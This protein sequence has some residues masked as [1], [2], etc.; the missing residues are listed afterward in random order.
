MLSLGRASYSNQ[1]TQNGE[2]GVRHPQRRSGNEHSRPIWNVG[3]IHGCDLDD[4][5]QAERELQEVK[6]ELALNASIEASRH[7]QF[8]GF[9]GTGKKNQILSV[10]ARR[11]RPNTLIPD[12]CR[13]GSC[14]MPD[15]VAKSVPEQGIL[16]QLWHSKERK[17][18]Q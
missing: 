16:A 6:G 17:G 3:G 18:N 9:H 15:L 13:V 4:W 5:L 11:S 14:D 2:E 7:E 10:I 12:V 8:E 1:T